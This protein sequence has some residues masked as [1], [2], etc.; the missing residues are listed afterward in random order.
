MNYVE[1]YLRQK[2]FTFKKEL[3][4]CKII[5]KPFKK[6][7]KKVTRE[8]QKISYKHPFYNKIVEGSV[9]AY[10]IY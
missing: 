3:I 4:E 6:T 1:L 8:F 10:I 5:G 7:Y 2:N 9:P